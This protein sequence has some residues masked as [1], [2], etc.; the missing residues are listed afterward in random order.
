MA[1]LCAVRKDV[2]ILGHGIAGA[3][4][5]ESCRLRG[6]SVHVF[7]RKRDGNASMAAGGAV[8]PVVLRRDVPIWRAAELMLLTH[9]F[10][11][12]WE[13]HLGIQCWHPLPLV[14]LFPTPNE[15]K[16]WERAM[17]DPVTSQFITTRP[18]PE[19][20]TAP[21]RA[22][23]GYGTVTDAAWLDL[24]MLL[25]EHRESLMRQ[26]DL[27]EAN[28]D[29]S[30]IKHEADGVRIGE[31]QGRWIVDCT[32]PFS[33][34]PGMVPVKGETLTV[35][36][37]ELHLTRMIHG[38]VGLLPLGDHLFRV[39]AT[40]KWTDVWEGP[41]EEARGSLLARLQASVNAP[42][43]VVAQHAGVRPTSQDRRPILG[44][45]GAHSALLNG[46]G[47]RGVM[48]APWCTEHLLAHLFDGHTLDP[49]VDRER[50][51]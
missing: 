34:T 20:E 25:G 26:D 4:L 17:A 11:V 41:T 9:T 15:V 23:H 29:R 46:L 2:L 44:K 24:P 40:F 18:E 16:Q 28:V 19:I 39:G 12:R 14:K 51:T 49:E 35:R 47:V 36:I 21:L 10:Y 42:I 30:Q 32:G 37:P 27:T 48:L 50:F 33:S 8:N 31:V 43:E 5:A 13:Q 22:P 6:L 3:V 7:D 38:S 45:T 1:H